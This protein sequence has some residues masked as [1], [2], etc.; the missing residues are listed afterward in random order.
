MYKGLIF[1]LDGTLLDT[2][3]NIRFVL[4][5]SLKK[6][7]LPE[8]SYGEVRN[9]IGNGARKLVERAVGKNCGLAEKV[10]K[11][12][13]EKFPQ[14]TNE[15]TKLYD[16]AE[17]ALTAFRDAGIKLAVVT[18]KPQD[19][20]NAVFDKFLAKFGFCEVLGQTEY[21]PLKPNPE[22][23]L[24]VIRR[25]GLKKDECVFIGDGET[26]VQT[27]QAAQIK[28]ISALWGYRSREQLKAA[29]ASMFAENFNELAA[30]IL[31]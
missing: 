12:Y 25:F 6:F 30:M 5:Q 1:D 10:Y 3:P 22:S 31:K 29:G 13:A 11:Y 8:L 9:Y 16:G 7:N 15:R 27:A 4:N 14:C 24:E 28:C 18:N 2:V 17:S 20:T 23:T 26:D 19:A 21:Y